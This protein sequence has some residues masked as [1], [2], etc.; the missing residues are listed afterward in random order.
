MN[1]SIFHFNLKSKFIYESPHCSYFYSKLSN[2]NQMKPN[3]DERKFL[4]EYEKNYAKK[5]KI[6]KIIK[7]LKFLKILQLILKIEKKDE[8][9]INV[10]NLLN[11]HKNKK[12]SC[13]IL[14]ELYEKKNL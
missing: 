8:K 11:K 9:A 6:I 5:T 4:S 12:I 13:R 1:P 3:K 2:K 14:C 10:Q 7:S